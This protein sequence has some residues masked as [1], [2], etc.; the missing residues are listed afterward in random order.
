MA[1]YKRGKCRRSV[2][3]TLCTKDRW[4][5]NSA[6]RFKIKGQKFLKEALKELLEDLSD[7]DIK[8]TK[9]EIKEMAKNIANYE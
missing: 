1:N 9:E 3:C 2:R 4:R 5:G 6:D 8:L 7:D